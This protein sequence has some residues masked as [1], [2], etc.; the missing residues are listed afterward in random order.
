METKDSSVIK[1]WRAIACSE[2][3]PEMRLG[4]LAPG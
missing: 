2:E 1:G 4:P 3:A